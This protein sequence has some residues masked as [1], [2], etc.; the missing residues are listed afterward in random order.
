M[1]SLYIS[2]YIKKSDGQDYTSMILVGLIIA[3]QFSQSVLLSKIH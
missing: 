1:I 2:K 3:A